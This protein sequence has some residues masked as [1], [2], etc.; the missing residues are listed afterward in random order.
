MQWM[1]KKNH[2]LTTFECMP[3]PF[4]APSGAVT[5][6]K[7]GAVA[8]EVGEDAGFRCRSIVPAA[9]EIPTLDRRGGHRKAEKNSLKVGNEV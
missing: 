9:K 8:E 1:T 2:S 5:V 4:A 3:L 6:E 7:V